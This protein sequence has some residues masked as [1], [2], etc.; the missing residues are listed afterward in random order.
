MKHI[1]TLTLFL[2]ICTS[3]S[4]S[5][6]FALSIDIGASQIITADKV[7]MVED[8]TTQIFTQSLLQAGSL[9]VYDF[10]VQGEEELLQTVESRGYVAFNL[11]PWYLEGIAASQ[12]DSI[13]LSFVDVGSDS[14]DLNFF[15]TTGD[16]GD[17]YSYGVEDLFNMALGTGL[18]ASPIPPTVYEGNLFSLDV[19]AA[20]LDNFQTGTLGSN[21]AAFGVRDADPS[22]FN[23]F[24]YL[25]DPL[26]TINYT[27][28]SGPGTP[29]VPEPGTMVMLGLG[30][31]GYL[32]FR[33][34]A[35]N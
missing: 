28:G 12:I 11:D 5:P 34:K 30:I 27:Q 35:A 33:K 29:P 26:L 6:V 23:D 1:K 8:D 16:P 3:L 10:N 22:L 25:S 31:A 32:G 2:F 24:A 21:W 13:S 17:L 9:A 18:N 15:E 7:Y 14:P 19:T 4:F 20:F